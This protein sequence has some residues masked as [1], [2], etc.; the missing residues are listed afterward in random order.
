MTSTQASAHALTFGMAWA[1]VPRRRNAT[2]RRMIRARH[3]PMMN[4]ALVGALM[5]WFG[6]TQDPAARTARHVAKAERYMTEAKYPEAVIEYRNALKFSPQD[7]HTLFRLG[8][9]YLNQGS[10]GSAQLAFAALNQAVELDPT[11]WDAQ[12]KLGELLALSRR[13]DD[14]KKKAQLVLE[15]DPRH[16]DALIL[17]ANSE[18]GADRPVAARE[19][20]EQAKAAHPADPKPWLVEA[21]IDVSARQV[22][23]AERALLEAVRLSPTS[24]EPALALGNL[25]LLQGKRPE[26]ELQYQRAIT[27]KPDHLRLYLT[28]A[29]F[30]AAS[31]DLIKADAAFQDAV[32]RFP[33]QPAARIAYAHYLAT[34]RDLDGAEKQYRAVL[35][36]HPRDV[37]AKAQLATLLLDRQRPDDARLLVEELKN[38]RRGDPDV[39]HLAAR[40]LIA[41]KDLDGAVTTLQEALKA[42]PDNAKIHQTLGSVFAM[43]GDI[44]QAKS[45]LA[46]AIKAQP[47][48]WDARLALAGLH[49]RSRSP[50]LALEEAR[51]V[52]A[53][54]PRHPVALQLAG[55]A[56]LASGKPNEALGQYDALIAVAPS[57][58]AGYFRKGMAYRALQKPSE[59]EGQFRNALDRAP[60]SPE[61]VQQLVSLLFQR[62]DRSGA[63]TLLEA[64]IKKSDRPA[65]LHH[66]L[67]TVYAAMDDPAKAE[68]QHQRAIDLDKTFLPAY[69]ALGR[70]YARDPEKVIAQ[71][72]AMI[73]AAPNNPGPHTL[74]GMAYEAEQRYDDAILE[75]ERALKLEPRF[76]PAANNLAWLYAERGTNI[77]VALNLAQTAM[78]QLPNDPGVAD[79]LGWLY[80]KKGAYLKA[81]ALLRESADK[82][83]DNA[84]V[85]YHLGMALYKNSDAPA[86]KQALKRALALD[87]HFPGRDEATQVLAA[88]DPK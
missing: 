41:G 60:G 42:D 56:L 69:A 74:L 49:L 72:R 32:A 39:L 17:L 47:Q 12:V 38:E 45:E 24:V 18:W 44:P 53:A 20:L 75:Y 40:V 67:G 43:R 15:N 87:P 37:A 10:K 84:T 46:A 14:A 6:C 83:P 55:D 51:A 81:I 64:Q 63:V 11:L 62:D 68:A 35:K 28:L 5:A 2:H 25:Y 31:G 21:A 70:L 9:A 23:A 33:T 58:Y 29:Q 30:Y 76:A 52:L 19:A 78:E 77:D 57:S 59:A 4:L 22:P 50:D 26:A 66:V 34:R 7:A 79:T 61:V 80:Y 82:L 85:H 54:A 48:A 86:A 3:S 71:Y 16:L 73:D 27:L 65:A 36:D 8:M 1:M 88:L 13:F